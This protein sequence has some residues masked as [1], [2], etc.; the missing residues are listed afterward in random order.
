MT[1]GES[2]VSV[3][4]LVWCAGCRLRRE[5]PTIRVKMCRSTKVRVM[6]TPP[7]L[8]PQGIDVKEPY[9]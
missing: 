7:P 9:R 4:G 8:R 2:S 5:E 6:G 1:L 3:G